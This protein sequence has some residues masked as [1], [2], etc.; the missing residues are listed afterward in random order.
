MPLVLIKRESGEAFI[1]ITEQISLDEHIEGGRPL[2][3][4]D[5]VDGKKVRDWPVGVFTVKELVR[6]EERASER[7][8]D[9]SRDTI[10]IVKKPRLKMVGEDGN[11]FAIV[12]RALKVARKA[13]WS[14]EQIDEY[15]KKAQSG[16]YNNL[17]RVTMEYFDTK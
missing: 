13:G 4:D 8:T 17:L 3:P 12:G 5:V 6:N 10:Q 16:D 15:I 14:K 1:S 9:W 2:S 7:L 11:A